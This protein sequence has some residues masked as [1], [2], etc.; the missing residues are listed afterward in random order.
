VRDLARIHFQ[1][2]FSVFITE[3][4]LAR[5]GGLVLLLTRFEFE[6]SFDVIG[7]FVMDVC[8]LATRVFDALFAESHDQAVLF[9]RRLTDGL[10]EE[11]VA[12][13]MYP[14]LTRLAHV[15]DEGVLAESIALRVIRPCRAN[16]RQ[17]CSYRS[18][19]SRR[20]S[21][22][23]STSHS[24]TLSYSSPI[25]SRGAHAQRSSQRASSGSTG[26]RR[27]AALS[28]DKPPVARLFV[29]TAAV[30]VFQLRG[31]RRTARIRE[32]RRRRDGLASR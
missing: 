12:R 15:F 13:F 22:S 30:E 28:P 31:R 19:R 1:R 32:T 4:S 23:Q 27:L 29:P 3:R 5:H 25:S 20:R 21:G 7:H 6:L 14:F 18:A 26:S 17:G 11:V 10:G 16:S 24:S 9:T 2:V 8:V